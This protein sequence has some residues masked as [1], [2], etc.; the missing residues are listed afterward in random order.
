MY[1]PA[2]FIESNL[3]KL[4]DFIEQNSFGLLVSQVDG[5]P[6]ASHLPFLLERETGANGALVGHMAR[7]NLQWKDADGQIGLAIFSG[8][9][10]YVSPSWYEAEQVVPTWNYVSVHIYG[11][12]QVIND[13]AAVRTIVERT[14]G[15][16]EQGMA[17]PW[18]FDGSTAFA[19]RMLSQIVG[20]RLEMER[21]EG[22]WKLNQN[23]PVERRQKVIQVLERADD[24]NSRAI[25]AMMRETLPSEAGQ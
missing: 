4:Q 5:R 8:P 18:T 24:E 13:A 15:Y 25:A 10:A 2:A 9:H 12:L 21:L 6:F 16:Y 17:Q 3:V 14:V 19:A 23:H 22:K 1:I 7:A 20:F 11:K